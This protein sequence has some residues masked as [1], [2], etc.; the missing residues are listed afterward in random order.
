LFNRFF[1]KNKNEKV[2][3]SQKEVIIPIHWIEMYQDTKF[4]TSLSS[5]LGKDLAYIKSQNK[6]LSFK[7][8]VRQLDS[9]IMAFQE[10]KVITETENLV[11]AE[12]CYLLHTKQSIIKMD[13]LIAA[14][15][16]TVGINKVLEY[17]HQN[18]TTDHLEIERVNNLLNGMAK[19]YDLY[20]YR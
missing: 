19:K 13:N 6:K 18:K 11:E 15:E 12:Y 9:L 3:N 8:Y 4:V 16:T 7:K 20:K 17:I 2:S 5:N 10:I 1:E 14:N